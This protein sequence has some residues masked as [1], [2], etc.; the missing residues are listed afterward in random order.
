M[1]ET[2]FSLEALKF[3]RRLAAAKYTYPDDRL[4]IADLLKRWN[5]GLDLDRTER[6]M[7]LRLARKQ[8]AIN[9]PELKE[10]AV[11]ELASVR[12]ALGAEE[13]EPDAPQPAIG[14]DDDDEIELD[15]VPHAQ[16]AWDGIEDV[17][18]DDSS[19]AD[20]DEDFYATARKDADD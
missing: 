4:A 15:L 11:S 8:A 10:P 20:F 12:K 2:P 6:R 18:S 3:S 7:A 14:G 19:L 5:M 17:R 1:L 9:L 16:R 13:P